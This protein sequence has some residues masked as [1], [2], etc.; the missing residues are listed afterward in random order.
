MVTWKYPEW[1]WL[2]STSQKQLELELSPLEEFLTHYIATNSPHPSKADSV[3]TAKYAQTLAEKARAKLKNRRVQDAWE[4]FY[5][6]ELSQYK[7]MDRQEIDARAGKILFEDA[8]LLN[9]G[10]KKNVRRLIGVA[11]GNGDWKL[12]DN[13]DVDKVVEARRVV[14]DYYNDKYTCLALTLQQLSILATVAILLSVVIMFTL[15]GIPGTISTSISTTNL[16]FWFTVG[17]FGGVGGSISGL[18]GLQDAFALNNDIPE[19]V[20]NKWVTIAK[21]VIGF[22]AAVIIAIF[23]I[24]GLVQ[25]SNVTISNYVIYAM[26]FVSGFSERLI[27]GAVQ[28]R[29]PS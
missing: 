14:Q 5:E 21:P 22:S 26:A 17:L 25:V 16:L 27:I 10:E 8:S 6:A 15:T 7:L 2:K 12:Q 3:D 18:L 4:L 28:A 13:L 24:G 19:K 23:V 20:L 9:D 1:N 11:S 29:L